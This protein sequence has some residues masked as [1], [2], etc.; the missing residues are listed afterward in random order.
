MKLLLVVDGLEAAS[1]EPADCWLSDLSARLAARGHRVTAVCTRPAD[2]AQPPE[3]PAGVSVRRPPPGGLAAALESAFA[4]APDVVHLSVTGALDEVSVGLLRGAPLLVDMHDFSA[5]CANGDL[6]PRPDGGLCALHHPHAN[7][8]PC[9]GLSRLRAIDGRFR[10]ARE[11]QAVVAHSAFA[12][13]RARVA[14]DRGV[15]WVPYGADPARFSPT[16]AAPLSPEVAALA[17][18][19]DR[20]RVLLLGAP[21]AHRGGG[22]A[23]DLLVALNARLAGVELV[24]AGR[25]PENPEVHQVV[26]AEAREMGLDSQLQVLPRVPA[27]DLPALYAACDVA[28]APDPAPDAGGLAL[29]RA[30][31]CGV[32]VVAHPAGAAP[33]VLADGRDGLLVPS[34]DVGAF[35]TAL[36][37]LLADP[38]ARSGL[39][40]RAR[41]AAI[42]RFDIERAVFATEELYAR[43]RARAASP[44]AGPRPA[45]PRR[46]TAA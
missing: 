4:Q 18:R 39:S 2:A 23:G 30:L 20:P 6:V 9:A 14:L 38:A 44:A 16:P 15:A 32:P 45:P 41:L 3:S 31:A 19:R 42:E 46:R 37:G 33:E 10:L 22:R 36:A 29:V 13:D 24:V 21:T 43:V 26:L 34:G 35:A 5:I 27:A 7:C 28:A 8:G 40:E 1:L 25:D 17:T 12:R 11:A